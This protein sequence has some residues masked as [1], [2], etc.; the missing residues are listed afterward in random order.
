MAQK[1]G[2]K[3]TEETKRKISLKNKGNKSK[4]GQH[5]SLD[6]RKKISEAN[7]GEKCHFW[8][9]G[10]TNDPYP[11]DWTEILKESIRLRDNYICQEC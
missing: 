11:E 6:T 8:K 4:T 10:I 5:N 3:H 2:F 7:K 9:G 1:K